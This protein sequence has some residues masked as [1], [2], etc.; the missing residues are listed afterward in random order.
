MVTSDNQSE[1]DR[2]HHLWVTA[3]QRR[4]DAPTLENRQAEL[5]AR[6]AFFG[7]FN[8]NRTHLT[9]TSKWPT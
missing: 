4:L 5:R 1:L 3:I 7:V 9:D 6:T 2:L 8:D